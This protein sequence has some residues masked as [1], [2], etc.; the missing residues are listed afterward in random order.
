MGTYLIVKVYLNKNGDG[1]VTVAW[2][3]DCVVF[4]E[5]VGVVIEVAVELTV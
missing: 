4:G 5:I 3:D 1:D 2:V